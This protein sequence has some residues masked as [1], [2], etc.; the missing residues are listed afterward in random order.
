MLKL[1]SIPYRKLSTISPADQSLFST[2][3]T[4]PFS[5]VVIPETDHV[6]KYLYGKKTALIDG[7]TGREVQESVVN[8]ASGLVRSGMQK[9]GVLT[10]IFPNSTEFCTTFFSALAMGGIMS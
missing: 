9:G 2:A 5:E 7:V 1:T 6:F 3:V 4:S 10:L 8:I